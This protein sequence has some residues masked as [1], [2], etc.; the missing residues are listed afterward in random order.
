MSLHGWPAHAQT[1]DA[2]YADRENL[3]SARQAVTLLTDARAQNPAAFDPAWQLARICYWMGAHAPAAER[4]AF[5]ER[6]VEAAQAAARLAPDR[7]EGHFWAAATMGALAENYGMRVGLRYRKP[8][9]EELE[10]VLRLDP[11]FMQG[12][13]DRALG[14]YYAKV[15]SLLGGSR[16][17]AERH[18]RAS[19]R[20][21][22]ESTISRYFL[23]ELLLDANR[24]AEAR[25]ELQHV[26]DA[27]LSEDWAPEDRDYKSRA[28][29]LLATLR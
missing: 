6:G 17:K 20:Y 4:R 2:L 19:L 27:P 15:P 18:L 16:E 8:I 28:T 14:R 25:A 7:P 23:A 11:A 21:N 22:P 1:A 29:A 13:A 26:I 10:I 9:R 12:S 3:A 5:L 24:K